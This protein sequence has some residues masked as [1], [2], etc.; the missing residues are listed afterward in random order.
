[1]REG[2]MVGELGALE[3]ILIEKSELKGF[4]GV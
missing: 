4:Q 3:V 1:M 2:S